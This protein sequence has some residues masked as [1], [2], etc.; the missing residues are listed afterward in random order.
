MK[1]SPY[2]LLLAGLA[3]LVPV[4]AADYSITH[5]ATN[6]SL[7]ATFHGQSGNFSLNDPLNPGQQFAY[8]IDFSVAGQERK[9]A[10]FPVATL[11]EIKT[12]PGVGVTLS[13]DQFIFTSAASTCS[14]HVT[15]TAPTAPGSY[16]VKIQPNTPPSSGLSAG[17]G[18]VV[19]FTVSSAAPVP[20]VLALT[21]VP[22]CVLYHSNDPVTFTA[23]LTRL[24]N[25]API[26]GQIIEFTVDDQSAGAAPTDAAG[27]AK[28]QFVPNLLAVGDHTV[29]ATFAANPPYEASSAT[30]SLGVHYLFIGYQQPINADGTSVFKGGTI[31]VK[32]KIS[33]AN[34]NAVPD[35]GPNLFYSLLAS[36]TVGTEREPALTNKPD[37]GNGMK[38]DPVADQYILN[39]DISPCSN[40]T[41]T[42]YVDLHEGRCG[43]PH[44]VVISIDRKK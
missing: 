37:A 26:S 25:G 32:I 33:D 38:Y 39:W 13:L 23:T 34:G 43:E 44:T 28:F 10:V 42:L 40:G 20:T 24:D 22:D 15:V 5:V 8:D 12:D 7:P 21:V 3:L 9:T 6:V 30:A 4:S 16:T 27:Q 29:G 35:A 2:L 31:P 36:T 1:K 17:E 18:I 14:T 19:N 41:Y 11:F